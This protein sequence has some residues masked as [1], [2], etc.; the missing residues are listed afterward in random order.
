[1]LDFVQTITGFVPRA[2]W[3][4]IFVVFAVGVLWNIRQVRRSGQR[5][6]VG[7]LLFSICGGVI[8][9]LAIF[10]FGF[11]GDQG[12]TIRKFVADYPDQTLIAHH[13]VECGWSGYRTNFGGNKPNWVDSLYDG[14][15][16][17]PIIKWGN[18]LLGSR[19]KVSVA[20]VTDAQF[21]VDL[22]KVKAPDL[23]DTE[24]VPEDKATGAPPEVIIRPRLPH[25]ELLSTQA[26]FTNTVTPYLAQ[27]LAD[28]NKACGGGYTRT[29][30]EHKGGIV[31][32]VD[33]SLDVTQKAINSRVSQLNSEYNDP[34][35][36]VDSAS[37]TMLQLAEQDVETQFCDLLRKYSL[38]DHIAKL[39]EEGYKVTCVVRFEEA[40]SK[41]TG[42]ALPTKEFKID[43][44]V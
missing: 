7:K 38:S 26:V 44:P 10:S 31:W 17:V 23:V 34:T 4:V 43:L 33:P 2:F 42:P 11:G 9:L 30:E 22:S 37:H 24:I 25:A 35:R 13:R 28:A 41:K 20:V 8:G 29:L 3:L 19:P 39:Q 36:E 21:G 27:F 32:R 1:M 18:S 16:K 12:I 15:D 6:K 14:I 40:L 5:W